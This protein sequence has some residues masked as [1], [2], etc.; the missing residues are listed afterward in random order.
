MAKFKFKILKAIDVSGLKFLD[1]VVRLLFWEEPRKQFRQIGKFIIIPVAAFVVFLGLWTWLAPRHT[2][3]SGEMPT[4]GVVWD[5]AQGILAF[6]QR[7]Q[8]KERAFLASD[9]EAAEMRTEAEARLETLRTEAIPEAQAR[10]EALKS[11][12]QAWL[13]ENVRPAQQQMEAVEAQLEARESELEANLESLAERLESAPPEARIELLEGIREYEALEDA[14]RR[15]L[16]AL[17]A[18]LSLVERR[19]YPQMQEARR[20]LTRLEE[21]RQFLTALTSILEETRNMRIEELN[22]NINQLVDGFFAAE[23]TQAYEQARRVVRYEGRVEAVA[24]SQY[25]AAKTLPYQTL[26]SLLCVF[27]GFL[28]ATAIAIPIGILCGIS[29]II[30]SALTPFIAL[31]KPVSPI[32]WLPIALIV[33]GGFIPDPENNPLLEAINA[34]PGIGAF[35]I[36]PAF[37]ASAIT[38]ALCS[39]WPT[40]VNTALGVASIDKDH[41]NVA[42]VLR[43]GFWSRLQKIVI[44]SAMPL[45]FAGLRISLGVGW[46]VLIAAELLASSEGIGKFV[47]DMF[48]NGSS[49]SLAQMFVVVFLVGLIGLLLDRIMIVFQ[50]LVTFDGAPTSL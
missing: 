44:P 16:A 18:E 23:G 8:L 13:N 11:D 17:Q 5:A 25:A 41:L 19:Q 46:M 35:E 9:E 12:E 37:L 2:T 6:H 20:E 45:I 38:V 1:P 30:M 50:R 21:E 15:E 29:P 32:V 48:N 39:L 14:N 42:R 22:A 36:N 27:A 43:L 10:V 33:V 49:D 4:P 7:E 34:I 40:L 28:L 31:F 26:R 3:K 24:E 47:W